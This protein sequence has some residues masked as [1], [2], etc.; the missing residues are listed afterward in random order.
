MKCISSMDTHDDE[1][2]LKDACRQM[3]TRMPFER[4]FE[5]LKDPSDQEE[6]ITLL[7]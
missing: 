6:L 3:I 1:N 2:A 7:D 5:S 4:T